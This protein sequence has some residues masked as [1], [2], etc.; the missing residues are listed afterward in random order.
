MQVQYITDQ[1]G[2]KTNVIIPYK[3]WENLM[4]ELKKQRMLL[5]LKESVSEVKAMLSGRKKMKTI[6]DLLDD[7]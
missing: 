2:H 6:E 1:K 7:L 4:E 5:G 3:E